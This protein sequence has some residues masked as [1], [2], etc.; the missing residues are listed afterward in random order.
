MAPLDLGRPTFEW[1]LRVHVPT[2]GADFVAEFV[3]P[4]FALAG[5]APAGGPERPMAARTDVWRAAGVREEPLAGAVGDTAL[6]LPAKVGRVHATGPLAMAVVLG[7]V[8]GA[9]WFS[10]MPIIF[11]L[12]LSG[13]ALLPLLAVWSLLQAGGERLWVEREAVCSERNGQ[14]RRLALA[15]L[16]PI[17][18][19]ASVSV[20]SKAFFRVESRPRVAGPPRLPKKFVFA[21]L[22]PGRETAEHVVAWLQERVDEV[23]KR[24]GATRPK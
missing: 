13:F 17:E 21:A 5:V 14:V 3:L 10:P 18:Q 22:V 8:A 9:L 20:G 15:E 11:P 19:R 24:L 6:V 23:G 1:R 7:G 2:V 4:V 12:F 16:G